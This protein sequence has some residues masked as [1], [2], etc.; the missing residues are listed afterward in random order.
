MPSFSYDQ[1]CVIVSL[2][3]SRFCARCG[4]LRDTKMKTDFN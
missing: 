1:L 3:R 2:D 4:G